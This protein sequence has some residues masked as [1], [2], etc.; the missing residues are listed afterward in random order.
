MASTAL[1]IVAISLRGESG[2]VVLSS[3]SPVGCVDSD[4]GAVDCALRE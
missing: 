3:S 1:G 4:I 2:A